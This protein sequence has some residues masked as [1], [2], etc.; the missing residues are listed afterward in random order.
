[1]GE[2]QGRPGRVVVIE[3]DEGLGKSR[4]LVEFVRGAR[5]RDPSAVILSGTAFGSEQTR[6]YAAVRPLIPQLTSARGASAAPAESLAALAHLAPEGRERYRSLPD[7]RADE[8][9]SRHVERVVADVAEEQPLLLA[10]DDAPPADSAIQELLGAL[11]RRPT[12]R[13]LLVLAGRREAWSRSPLGLDLQQASG[14]VERLKLGPLSPSQVEAL[15][16][17]MAPFVP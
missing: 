15:L 7:F 2:C 3:G 5:T 8:P 13:V 11:V 10:L 4:L 1:M 16:A 17:S 6:P 9:L 14:R 12:R